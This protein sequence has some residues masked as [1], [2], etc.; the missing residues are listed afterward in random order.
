MPS[1]HVAYMYVS[2][3]LTH[4]SIDL[5]ILIVLVCARELAMGRTRVLY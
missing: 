4:L 3:N 5:A 1:Y 2:S